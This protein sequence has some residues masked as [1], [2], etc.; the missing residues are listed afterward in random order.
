MLGTQVEHL[1]SFRHFTAAGSGETSGPHNQAH[2]VN[3][4]CLRRDPDQTQGAVDTERVK[5]GTEFVRRADDVEDE[6]EPGGLGR[7]LS[8]VGGDDGITRTER[9]S[10]LGLAR[11]GVNTL[12]SAPSAHATF[13]PM[14]PRPPRP[15][16]P[17]T[18]PWPTPM[19]RSGE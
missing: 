11:R 8:G 10:R 1:L 16:T 4:R 12:T 14:C 17:T 18:V 2:R 7:H 13:T 3:S 9:Q 5:V 15:I 6:V 19:R